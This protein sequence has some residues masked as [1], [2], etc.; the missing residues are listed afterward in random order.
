[1]HIYDVQ[2]SIWKEKASSPLK[3]ELLYFLGDFM[4]AKKLQLYSDFMKEVDFRAQQM[5]DALY[6]C[7][8]KDIP[9]EYTDLMK[10]NL[11][12]FCAYTVKYDVEKNAKESSYLERIAIHKDPFENSDAIHNLIYLGKDEHFCNILDVLSLLFNFHKERKEK[13]FLKRKWIPLHQ[14]IDCISYVMREAYACPEYIR[15]KAW[16]NVHDIWIYLISSASPCAYPYCIY[17]IFKIPFGEKRIAP[18]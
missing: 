14:C 4:D 1:M 11:K 3:T 9:D 10:N 12:K 15:K 16:S 2:D 17:M 5:Y 18:R 13:Q 8:M 6:S 7:V